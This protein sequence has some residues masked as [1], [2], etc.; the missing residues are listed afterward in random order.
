MHGAVDVD[1]DAGDRQAALL[2]PLLLVALPLELRVGEH[3]E[4]SVG[5]D[6][7]DEQPLRHPELRRREADAEGVPHDPRHAPHLA[8]Q[9]VVE[10]V[11]DS[12]LA[13][14]DRVAQAADER[15]S[16]RPARLELGIELRLLFLGDL[17]GHGLVRHGGPIVTVGYWGSTSTA[18]PAAACARSSATASTASRTASIAGARSRERIRSCARSLP[19]RRNSGAGPSTGVPVASSSSRMASAAASSGPASSD[20]QT[21][22]IKLPKGGYESASRRSS[23]S[24]KKPSAS[25]PAA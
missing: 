25:C 21:T 19:W 20:E 7:V 9:G 3:D 4:R 10:A 12:G 16:G 8:A 18:K 14:Q 5:P 13:L 17:V 24:P 6:A 15:H 23:S 2:E 1:R 11:D 22:R